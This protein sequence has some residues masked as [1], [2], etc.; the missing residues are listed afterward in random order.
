MAHDDHIELGIAIV[1]MAGRFPG[2]PSVGALWRLLREGR[3]GIRDLTDDELRA[4]GSGGWLDDPRLVRRAADL[5]DADLFDAGLFGFTPREAE[6]TDPQFRVFLEDAW[7]ALEDAGRHGTSARERTGV[8]AGASPETYYLNNVLPSARGARAVGDFQASIGNQR[9]YLATQLSYRLDLRGPSLTVQTACSTSLVAVHLAC[10]SLL[11]RECDLALAGGVSVGVPQ[12][13]GYL[14]EEGGIA[15]PDGR[16]RA[17]D[18]S[19]SGCVKGNGSGV[20]VLTAANGDLLVGAATSQLNIANGQA[21]FHF[22]WRDSIT[23]RNGTTVSN[24]GKFLKHRPPGLVVVATAEQQSNIITILI[25][26]ILG[27]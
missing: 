7:T 1:G 3:E 23:L 16:C 24:T 6:I 11:A 25:R 17:F 2:A 14:H 10:Q 27:R 22:S 4:A 8:F 5:A 21:D 18:A 19:A 9:D 12:T 13:S 26:I 20:V 15:S